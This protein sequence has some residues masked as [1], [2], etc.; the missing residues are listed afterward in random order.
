VVIILLYN[1]ISEFNVELDYLDL[2]EIILWFICII[3]FTII[4]IIFYLNSKKLNK[5][6]IF[7][8]FF[9]L[10][11]NIA[12][13]CRLISKFVVGYELGTS[14][15]TGILLILAILY[16]LF[17]YSGLFLF[18]FFIER[19]TMRGTH[20]FF[21]MLVI[22]VI[23]I[24]FINYFIKIPLLIFAPP[25]LIMLFGV[26]GFYLYL[27][28]KTSG[29]KRIKSLSIMIGMIMVVLGSAFDAPTI[30]S[31]LAEIPNMLE[32]MKFTAPV[33][34]IIGAILIQMGFQE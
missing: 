24:T 3:I 8:T 13:V 11:Y 7:A 28:I 6:Y 21:S 16:N 17:A 32:F 18:Y 31:I 5:V 19:K 14:D 25:Y 27:A 22:F 4:G 15:F 20:Y 30:V 12:R 26:A 23:I 2:L 33:L 10:L 1:Y 34:Q 29:A 9:F